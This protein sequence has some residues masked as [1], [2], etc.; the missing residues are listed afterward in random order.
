MS[1]PS[2]DVPLAGYCDRLS[3]RPGDRIDFKVSSACATSFHARLVRSISADPNPDGPGIL[4]EETA[5]DFTGD[6]PSRK[7]RFFPGSYAN[8][9]IDNALAGLCD[10][11]LSLLIWPTT[12]DK[13]GQGLMAFAGMTL[14][15]GPTGA[16]VRDADGAVLLSAGEGLKSRHW[17]R[18]RASYSAANKTLWVSQEAL[19]SPGTVHIGERTGC[20]GFDLTGTLL[21]AARYT[22]PADIAPAIGGH[23]NGKLEAPTIFDVS[24]SDQQASAI[25]A[26]DFSREISSTRIED[27]GPHGLHGRLVN[28]P[29]RAMTGSKWTGEEMN[30]NHAPDHYAAIHFHDDDIY[31]FGWETDFSFTIPEDLKSGIYAARLSCEGHEDAIPF[32]VCPPKGKKRADLC[33]LVS[34]FTYVIY[35][36]HARPDYRPSWQ[37]RIKDWNAYPNNPAEYRQYGLSTYNDHSDGSGICHASHKRPLFNMRPGYLTFG[38]GEGS[39]LRHFQADSHLISWLEAKG[40]SYDIVTDR[41]L[42]NDGVDAIKSYRCVTTGSHPEYHT[43][44]TLDALK[45]FRDGGGKLVYLGGNGFYWR[46]ALHC[47]DPSTI[48][49]RRAESGIRA[50]AAETGEYYNAFDGT[51]GGLW[52]RNGR[53]PQK[54]SGVGFSAQGQFTGSYYRKSADLDPSLSW[55]FEGIEDETFGNFGLSGGGAAGYELD[56]A[57]TRLGTPDNA[58]VLASSEAHDDTYIL[59]PE[60]LLTHIT[61]LPGDKTKDPIRADMLYC[62]FPGGGA[63]FS[64]GSITFCGSLPTND[65]DNPISTLLGNVFN[66]FLKP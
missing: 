20:D 16:E 61:S 43:A 53:P 11:T 50:W 18:V 57:D 54:L 3:G 40:L 51:Y 28:L 60:E 14:G 9:D 24:Q 56:R 17:Y 31:D 59:V 63:V 34:T 44:A 45:S 25:I 66:R 62:D 48:E 30:W 55:V 2:N 8:V 4:E 29:A 49:I 32:F 1:T 38:T 15:L 12:P 64:T 6:Y 36:N 42:Q 26:W 58:K 37:D 7:R 23:F 65:F 19:E 21:L 13:P 27:T 22:N 47:E 46:V 39:G 52:R 35:G 33:V 5:A 41:E 10:F